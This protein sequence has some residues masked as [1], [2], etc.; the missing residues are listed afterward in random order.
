[1]GAL[2]GLGVGVGLLLV[3]SAFALPRQPRA[4]TPTSTALGRLL[5]R[6]GLS[7]VTFLWMMERT[8]SRTQRS[9]N[10]T[11]HSASANMASR[12]ARICHACASTA[13][14]M[15]IPRWTKP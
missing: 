2:V 7:D 10:A 13:V 11:P 5:G 14:S 4:T 8:A 12:G 6:A 9:S 3:W 1:M 15:R